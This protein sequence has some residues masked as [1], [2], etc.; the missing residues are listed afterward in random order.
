MKRIITSSLFIVALVVSMT[1]CLKD[2][3][4]DN[5]Q[6]GINDPDTQPPGVGFPLAANKKN[7]FGLDVTGT[8]QVVSGL[9]YVNLESGSPASSDITITLTNTSAAQVAAYNTANGTTIQVMPAALYTTPSLT[10]TIPAGQR[11]VEIPINVLST[12]TLD[13]NK[14]YGVAF[15]ISSVTN[16]LKIASNLKDLFI[17]FSIKNKYD[18]KYNLR[19]YHN[20]TSPD[21]SAPYNTTVWM[22]T[23]GPNSI[24]MY[25]PSAG[26]Y[27]HPI[28]GGNSYYGSFGANFYFNLS[29]NLM[30]AWDWYP[31]ATTL[32]TAVGPA[33]DS[34]YD[35]AT[36]KIYANFYYNN[37]P[38]GRAFFDTLTYLGPR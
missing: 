16:N 15:S 28:L 36:K 22:I 38:G 19:G 12:L 11:N 3:G 18:G 26:T 5:N 7:G 30:T 13:P 4:F 33:V 9:V 21:Y 37:N 27:A 17:E 20:R 2:K 29:T 25:W 34:R 23:S 6:Y 35:P 8:T 31:Y 32:P 1:G 10:L 24:T 14:S